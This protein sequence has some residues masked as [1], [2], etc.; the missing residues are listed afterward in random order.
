MADALKFTKDHLWLRLEGS[1]VQIGISEHAQNALGDLISIELPDVGDEVEK[2]Q[3]FGEL[4]STKTVNELIAPINGEVVAI[5]TELEDHPNIVNEDPY[6]EGWLIEV[7]MADMGDL[8][9]PKFMDP[10]EYDDFLSGEEE[11]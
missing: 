11:A 3:S 7:E 8:D 1:R 9:D 2:D 6:H 4:E 5:N 10:D